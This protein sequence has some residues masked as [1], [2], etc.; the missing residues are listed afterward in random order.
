MPN[1]FTDVFCQSAD[2]LKL[3]AKTIGF[4]HPVTR[5]HLVFNSDIPADMTEV[6][7]ALRAQR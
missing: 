1:S 7:E 6:L 4:I 2:G 5:E 3:H